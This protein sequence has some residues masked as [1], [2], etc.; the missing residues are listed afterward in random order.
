MSNSTFLK[1]YRWHLTYLAL[2]LIGLFLR[3]WQ[4]GIIPPAIHHDEIYYAVEAQTIAVSASDPSGTWRPWHFRPAHVL[5]A[6][7]PGTVVALG[8]LLSSTPLIAAR[9]SSVVAGVVLPLALAW[10]AWGLFRRR[11][12][13][14][15]VTVLA[16]FNPWIFQFSRLTFD[17]LFSL[18]FYYLG[19]A[20]LINTKG[21]WRVLSL[22][23]L[24]LGFFQYQGLK[25]V[26]IPMMIITLLYLVYQEW[27]KRAF[28]GVS[29]IKRLAPLLVV[30]CGVL[31][32]FGT[33]VTRLQSQTAS[34]RIGDIIFFNEAYI[35]R[36]VD[37]QRRLS[38]LTPLT[39]V[40]VNKATVLSW[41]VLYKY[42]HAFH[43]IL[44]FVAGEAV[45]NPFSVWS[46]GIFHV[47]DFFLI[48]LGIAAM[49]RR[50]EWRGPGLFLLG[51]AVIAPLPLAV[52]TIEAWVIFRASF[53]FPILIMVAAVGWQSLWSQK[54]RLIKIS[55]VLVYALALTWFGY[56]YFFRY[57]V[58]ATAGSAFAERVMANYIH[59]LEPDTPVLILGDQG[60]FL[61]YAYLFHNQLITKANLPQI[62]ASL[63]QRQFQLNTVQV[64]TRCVPTS[65]EEST[66]V[67]ISDAVN[68]VCDTDENSEPSATDSVR[69]TH[70]VSPIDSGT[71]FRVYNDPLCTQYSLNSFSRVQDWE[72]LHVEALSDEEFC[73]RLLIYSD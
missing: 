5:Y 9:L 48:V 42:V 73:K 37:E 60:E 2:I 46:M 54:F 15:V 28:K 50:S 34:T 18:A 20:V 62:N 29:I 71:T 39:P 30:G 25:L 70:I 1:Q 43:P 56:Q 12:I 49:W 47:V 21:W 7:L 41:E 64:D 68:T 57:P 14:L 55:M 65:G 13:S 61:F 58:Y 33:Y 40:F 36:L 72:T 52:N 8:T 35:S 63:Q 19:L 24:A 10:L 66:K 16:L 11:E 23:P 31:L 27:P 69:V 38:I 44:L 26:F 3:L 17:S 4:L 53:L 59:R 22:L 67:I 32:I 51:L 6:E 45:R